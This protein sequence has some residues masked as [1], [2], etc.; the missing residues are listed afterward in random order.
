MRR[1]FGA[2]ALG[3]L[4]PSACSGAMPGGAAPSGPARSEREAQV[5]QR[6]SLSEGGGCSIVAEG[7]SCWTVASHEL[8]AAERLRPLTLALP[9]PAVD[10][11]GSLAFGCAVLASGAVYCWGANESGQLGAGSSVEQSALPLRSVGLDDATSVSVGPTHACAVRAEGTVACWGSNW[12]GQCGHDTEYSSAVRHLVVP[13]TVA[14]VTGA[15]RVSVGT[16]ASCAL[17]ALGATCWGAMLQTRE[18]FERA[19]DRTRATRFE[20]LSRARSLALGDDCGCVLSEDGRVGCFGVGP[21]GCPSVDPL[22][23][24]EPLFDG[25]RMQRLVVGDGGACAAREQGGWYCWLH[26][27]AADVRAG[28][29]EVMHYAPRALRAAPFAARDD[30]AFGAR[31]CTIVGASLRCLDLND[32]NGTLSWSE[33]RLE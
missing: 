27:V 12:A 23:G 26:P 24:L 20:P 4:S 30:V 2:L 19:P 6:L 10:V 16:Y 14:N 11:D 8:E 1:R 15:E 22:V 32:S 3:L 18:G 13:T 31:A 29:V 7:V 5:Q 17:G 28:G 25:Q 9:A 33:H 21:H